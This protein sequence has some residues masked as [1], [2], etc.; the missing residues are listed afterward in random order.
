MIARLFPTGIFQRFLD[1]EL[2]PQYAA[3]YYRLMDAIR[4]HLLPLGVTLPTASSVA[5][6]GYFVWI[7]LPPGMCASD[8][9]RSPSQAQVEVAAGDLFRVQADPHPR[10]NDFS[11]YLRLCF[12]WETESNL[13]QGVRRLAD[14]VREAQT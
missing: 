9:A 10:T 13:T 2:R 12:A 5:A 3:R 14:V 1:N 4:E 6:G 7:Q 11:R 8:L